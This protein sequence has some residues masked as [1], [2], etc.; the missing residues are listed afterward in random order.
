MG[1]MEWVRERGEEWIGRVEVRVIFDRE[2]CGPR[3]HD[4]CGE[5]SICS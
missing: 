2:V 1:C 5:E 4:A 3:D